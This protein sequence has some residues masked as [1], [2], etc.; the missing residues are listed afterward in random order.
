MPTQLQINQFKRKARAAGYSELQ[1]ANEISRKIR[2][3]STQKTQRQPTRP[4][5]QIQDTN[6]TQ[7][8]PSQPQESFLKRTVRGLVEPGVN[9][10][11]FIGEAGAQSIRAV[12]DP[13]MDFRGGKKI[14][15]IANQSDE[16]HKRSRE[17]IKKAKQT[18]DPEEKKRLLQQSR[19]IDAEIEQLTTPLRD[20]AEK[21]TTF[22]EDEE[23]IKDRGTILKTGIKRTAGGASY[24]IPGGKTLKAAIAS[25]MISGAL[26]GLSEGEDI[27]PI[28][29]ITGTVSGG[30]GG[31]AVF[32][33]SKVVGKGWGKVTKK[34][35]NIKRGAAQ[36]LSDEA[37]E[38]ITKASPSQWQK[39]VDDHGID[40]NDLTKKYFK[41][42]GTYDDMLGEVSK[43]GRGGIIQ[44]NIQK[45]EK[46]LQKALKNVNKNTKFTIDEIVEALT[47]EKKQLAKLP[48]NENNIKALEEFIKGFKAQYGKGITPKRLL[49]LKR[50]ADSQ[51]G[52]A[53]AD[54][55]TGSAIAQAQK[56]VANAARAK[57]KKLLPGVKNALDTEM[58]LYTLRPI[59]SRA[60]SILNT[61]GS[62]IRVGSL[63]G[64]NILELLNP[65]NLADTYLSDPKRASKLLKEAG[66]EVTEQVSKGGKTLFTDTFFQRLGSTGTTSLAVGEE[67][68]Q[69]DQEGYQPE[70]E[71]DADD[72]IDNLQDQD[73]LPDSSLAQEETNVFGGRSKQEIL[74]MAFRQG[75]NQSQLKEIGDIYDT[76]VPEEESEQLS[77]SDSAIKKVTEVEG[78]IA[79][80]E[81]LFEAIQASDDVGVLKGFKAKNPF[82]VDA[83]SLQAEI[84]RVRQVIGKA[85]EGGVLR[86]EDEEKYKKILPQITDSKDVALNKLRQLN[87]KLKTDLEL[88]VKLQQRYG[89]G[90]GQSTILQNIE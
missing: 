81:S 79:D 73:I 23:A 4:T 38:R 59:L 13:V 61:P 86:K 30:I 88:Y 56:M 49:D 67:P 26:Y 17:L 63:K 37:A 64:K 27:D 69:P 57:L 78:A 87:R 33:L 8:Q 10:L 32:G 68:I 58:E 75:A 60:R 42:G 89:K 28:D 16:L 21:P 9:Y 22:F 20:L 50:I 39:A 80:T 12:A 82:D 71:I 3:E 19:D 72:G 55:N 1:I 85:L 47:K 66:E 83:R 18:K 53:V 65:F 24:F 5:Q 6:I 14:D 11:K 46:S 34:L 31:G 7:P 77:L 70:E 84:D 48:G 41:R 36:K 52:R 40:L 25:G 74:Q 54:E 15:E 29:I 2:A 45:A 43:R 76:L 51:F 44:K 90:S 35:N 62:T